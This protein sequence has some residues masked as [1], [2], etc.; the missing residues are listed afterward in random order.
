[1]KTNNTKVFFK[2]EK[3]EVKDNSAPEGKRLVRKIDG[4]IEAIAVDLATKTE[5]ARRKVMLRHGDSPDKL[6]GRKYAF[7]KLTTFIM[8]NNLL[9]K[10]EVGSLWKE[11]G[12]NCK[13]PNIK[14]AY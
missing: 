10:E 3:Q 9:P 13:Q 8:E 4:V 1:M 12:S 2:Y 14:L 6:V 5:I 11:F 7:K